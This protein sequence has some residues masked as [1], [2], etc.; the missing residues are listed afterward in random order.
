VSGG[1]EVGQKVVFLS[2]QFT[3]IKEVIDF[4]EFSWKRISRSNGKLLQPIKKEEK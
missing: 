1:E 2:V 3:L 4:H